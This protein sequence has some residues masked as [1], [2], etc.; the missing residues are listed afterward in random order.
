MKHGATRT[1]FNRV[2]GKDIGAANTFTSS[3]WGGRRAERQRARRVGDGACKMRRPPTRKILGFFDLP[4]TGE[5]K[6]RASFLRNAP[7]DPQIPKASSI[8]SPGYRYGRVPNRLI[9]VCA[10]FAIFVT[11]PPPFPPFLH[12]ARPQN[13]TSGPTCERRIATFKNSSVH[14]LFQHRPS[15]DVPTL[16]CKA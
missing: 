8:P 3:L 2:C 9:S 14:G 4:T 7:F 5:V 1:Q 15:G 6:M 12:S 13:R 16:P 10:V 11:T